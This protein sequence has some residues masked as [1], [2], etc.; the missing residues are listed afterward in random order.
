MDSGLTE[1]TSCDVNF[2]M[3][4]LLQQC[5][6]NILSPRRQNFD[7]MGKSLD[8]FDWFLKK[9]L[10]KTLNIS[11]GCPYRT[12]P[13]ADSCFQK[14]S[15]VS[16]D[17]CFYFKKRPNRNRNIEP[18]YSFPDYFRFPDFLG[19]FRIFIK[20]SDFFT[21]WIVSFSHTYMT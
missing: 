19:F 2:D 3:N 10:Q 5:C 12:M 14:S 16:S 4:A 15:L 13:S 1:N 11:R 17:L 20:S 21:D 8:E 7:E 9:M 6:Q 18:W